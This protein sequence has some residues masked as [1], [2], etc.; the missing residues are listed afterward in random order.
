MVIDHG[1]GG[2]TAAH[3]VSLPGYMYFSAETYTSLGFAD[4][5]PDGS[6]RLLVGTEALNGLLLI[7]WSASIL[8]NFMERF[9]APPNQPHV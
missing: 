3:N 1:A 5:T 2:L 7:G 9:W 8:C 4:V 6:V